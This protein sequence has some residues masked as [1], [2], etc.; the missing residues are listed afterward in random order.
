MPRIIP[1]ERPMASPL[2][3]S[4]EE[5][6]PPSDRTNF[7]LAA[8]VVLSDISIVPTGAEESRNIVSAGA[9]EVGTSVRVSGEELCGAWDDGDWPGLIESGT[10]SASSGEGGIDGTVSGAKEGMD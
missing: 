7:D 8:K 9:S 3:L 2:L 5:S 10:C 1:K 6:S 4:D